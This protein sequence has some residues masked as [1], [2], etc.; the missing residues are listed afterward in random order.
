MLLNWEREL[1]K[2]DP[3]IN[4]RKTGGWLKTVEG[5]DKTVT[6]GY[7]IEGNF[8]KAGSYSEEIQTDFTLTVIRKVKNPNQNQITVL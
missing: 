3:S 5:L 7:S 2:L 8:I 6:N 1:T 4:F